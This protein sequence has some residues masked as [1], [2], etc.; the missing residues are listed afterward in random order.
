MPRNRALLL[1]ATAFIAMPSALHAQ[2]SGSWVGGSFGSWS[3]GSNWSSNP[4]FPTGGGYAT[5]KDYTALI[6][7][8]IGSVTLNGMIFDSRGDYT[9]GS[10]SSGQIRSLGSSISIDVPTSKLNKPGRLITQAD[11][12]K[13]LK[14]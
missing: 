7:L 8:D 11:V 12:D 10:F 5:F 2:V 4:L 9:I 1:A 13:F 6:P 3:T 14:G